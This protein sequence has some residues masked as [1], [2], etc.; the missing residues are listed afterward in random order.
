ML[1]ITN[2]IIKIVLL[3]WNSEKKMVFR[4]IGWNLSKGI[5]S[6]LS[7]CPIVNSSYLK[8]LV[9]Y[10]SFEYWGIEKTFKH[11]PQFHICHHTTLHLLN[12]SFTN[13]RKWSFTIKK[14]LKW[15]WLESRRLMCNRIKEILSVVHIY[16]YCSQDKNKQN[17]KV[18]Q[19]TALYII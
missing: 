18:Y 7:N 17:F 19:L 15:S 6:E 4:K 2:V 10:Q 9:R 11:K 5:D 8:S 12:F 1:D 13:F 16:L 14:K 3:I